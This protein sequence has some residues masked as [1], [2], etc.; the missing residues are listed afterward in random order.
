MAFS[1][2]CMRQLRQRPSNQMHVCYQVRRNRGEAAKSGAK[3]KVGLNILDVIALPGGIGRPRH[4][5]PPA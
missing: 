4:L 2:A 1:Y 5:C 3:Q